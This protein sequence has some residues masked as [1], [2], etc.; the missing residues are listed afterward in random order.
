VKQAV[1]FLNPLHVLFFVIMFAAKLGACKKI[2]TDKIL[3]NGILPSFWP[4]YAKFLPK[5]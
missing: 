3:Y 5:L 1:L 2:V 4:K